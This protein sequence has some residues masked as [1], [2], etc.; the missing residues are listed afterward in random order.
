MKSWFTLFRSPTLTIRAHYTWLLLLTLG[1]WTLVYS[2]LPARLGEDATR[3]PIAL[4]IMLVYVGCVVVHE[5]GHLVAAWT[6]RVPMP[7]LNVHPIGT[8]ARRG[9]EDVGPIRTLA[10]AAAG[11][12]ANLL[13]WF[14]LSRLEVTPATTQAVVLDFARSFTFVLALI[15]LLPGLPLDGGRILR[16][17]VWYGNNFN[18][19]TR[20]ATIGGYVVAVATLLYGLRTMTNST[21]TLRGVWIVLLAWL[22]YAAGTTLLRRRAI[23]SLFNRL[24][25]A[26]VMSPATQVAAPTLT[27][28]E[29]V[30][31]WRSNTGENPTPVVVKGQ[32]VGLI[33]RSLASNVPQGYWHKRT[34]EETMQPLAEIET[35]TPDTSLA[36]VLPVLD[37][38]EFNPLPLM[39]VHENR[40]MGLID[41]RDVV[42]LLD[43]QDVMGMQHATPEAKRRIHKKSRAAV[44]EHNSA[45]L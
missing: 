38:D 33:T 19:G 39:V 15:N 45:A 35:I 22:I 21:T 11:P 4:I 18:A 5:L 6:L 3:W 27:L 43:V 13:L 44:P 41:P 14:I 30:D 42:P 17:A 34:V 23:G 31:G 25:A 10:V 36:G 12:L 20:V 8:L 29:L 24:T 32:L 16:T 28:R 40:L 9:R 7:A 37:T 2:S 1:I 26:D